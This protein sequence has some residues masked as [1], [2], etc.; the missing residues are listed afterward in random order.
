MGAQK[1]RAAALIIAGGEADSDELIRSAAEKAAV[2]VAADKGL[3]FALRA[4]V[5]PDR[6]VGD[7]DSYSGEPPEGIEL[8]RLPI[9]KDDTDL[10][11]AVKLLEAEGFDELVIV[12]AMGGR[13]DHQLAVLQSLVGLAERGHGASLISDGCVITA[14]KGVKRFKKRNQRWLSLFCMGE[15]LRGVS[16]RGAK[17]CLENA[18]LEAGFPIGVSNEFASDEVTISVESGTALVMEIA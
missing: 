12:C 8:V 14:F 5:T 7:L 3:E 13:P 11:A 6:V 1:E 17:Y 18:T 10:E 4:G 2:V 16:I 9:E 15:P